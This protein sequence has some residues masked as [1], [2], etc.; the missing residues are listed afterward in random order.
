ML[1]VRPLQ[2]DETRGAG[3]GCRVTARISFSFQ[4]LFTLVLGV[5]T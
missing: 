2:G 1:A 5:N 4:I 3:T